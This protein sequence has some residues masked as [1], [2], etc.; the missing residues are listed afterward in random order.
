[1]SANV[2]KVSDTLRKK[3]Q[4]QRDAMTSGVVIDNRKMT[5]VRLRL[6]PCGEEVPGVVYYDS[7]SPAL[8]KGCTSP[9]T[10][11][12]PD[13]VLDVWDGWKRS[14]TP[15]QKEHAKNTINSGR[16][17][18]MAVLDRAN[19]GTV[20]APNIRVFRAK[21][22]VNKTIVDGMIDDED[23][24]DLTDAKT[25]RDIRV[26][27]APGTPKGENPWS[28]RVLDS[29]PIFP[30]ATDK[31]LAALLKVAKAFDVRDHF[32]K[33]NLAVLAEMHDALTG[34]QIPAEVM[35]KLEASDKC[36]WPEAD[37]RGSK[38]NARVGGGKAK[39]APKPASKPVDDDDED[40]E[41]A[42]EAEA[43]AGDG[44]DVKIEVGA[45]VKFTDE[46][47]GEITGK[48]LEIDEEK[49][50]ADVD[51]GENVW[52]VAISDLTL[53]EGAESEAAEAE[54]EAEAEEDEEE[55]A[56]KPKAKPKPK[57][58]AAEPEPEAEEEA[59]PEEVEEEETPAPKAGAVKKPATPVG[60]AKPAPKPA[61]KGSS[62][63]SRLAKSRK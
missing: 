3:L 32:F 24:T 34:E 40:E 58:K 20:E 38:P 59:E 50:T 55:E 39:P 26:I 6:L 44:A 62:L 30:D 27:K 53:V 1:M 23:G 21:Q 31:Q 29:E 9:R 47:E 61:A 45:T 57:A 35:E 17:Y 63:R 12:L 43:E 5:K 46:N 4:E 41:V 13:P 11:G 18:W 25:G 56:E 22:T 16:E 42:E 28:A 52:T 60:K 7:Y 48:V 8:N 37:G 33:V 54:P 14:G 2:R 10:F 15:E 51:G 36:Y 19:P 49:E